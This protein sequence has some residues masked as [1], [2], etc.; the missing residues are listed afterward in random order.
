MRYVRNT[1]EFDRSL[2]FF[3]AVF[4]FALTLLIANLDMPSAEAWQSL[5]TMLAGGT[6]SQLIGFAISF[7]VIVTFWRANQALVA[8]LRGLDSPAIIWNIVLVGMIIFIPFTTQGISDPETAEL[9]L[10]TVLYALNVTVAILAQIAMHRGAVRRGLARVEIPAR[11]A[12]AELIDALLK[13]AVFIL[14]IP[15]A[16]AFDGVVAKLSWLSLFVIG[17][18]SGRWVKRVAREEHVDVT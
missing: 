5:D 1:S 16:L 12:R 10:P 9:A 18:L 7:V 3:D 6:G 11:L 15:I 13:P 4:G 14:S 8:R 2:S 17:P